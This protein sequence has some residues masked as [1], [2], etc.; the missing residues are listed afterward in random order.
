MLVCQNNSIGK[1][2]SIP[3]G[4]VEPL[5]FYKR[6]MLVCQ[7]NSPRKIPDGPVDPL[8]ISTSDQYWCV[9]IILQEK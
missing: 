5:Y 3:E 8:Y 4:P 9:K 7:T 6:P 2:K 1:G